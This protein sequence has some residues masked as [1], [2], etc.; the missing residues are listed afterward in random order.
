[1]SKWKIKKK[2]EKTFLFAF[3]ETLAFYLYD[4]DGYKIISI[5][6]W[7]NNFIFEVYVFFRA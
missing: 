7:E 5:N 3:D 4:P 6:A 1:M 2:R